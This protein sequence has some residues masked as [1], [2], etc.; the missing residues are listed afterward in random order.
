MTDFT[1]KLAL[2]SRRNFS[3]RITRRR[4]PSVMV[5]LLR[6]QLVNPWGL[7]SSQSSM[8]RLTIT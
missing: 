7:V 8:S 4:L 6:I 3:S 1:A 2:W 5:S